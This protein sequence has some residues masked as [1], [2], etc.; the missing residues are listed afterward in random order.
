[1]SVFN[2]VKKQ[3]TPSAGAGGTNMYSD[4]GGQA[5]QGWGPWQRQFGN[6]KINPTDYENQVQSG[7]FLDLKNNPFFQ[8]YAQGAMGDMNEEFQRASGQAMSPFANMNNFMSGINAATQGRMVDQHSENVNQAMS[9]MYN[10]Q[11]G[12]ERDRQQQIA[13]ILSGRQQAQWGVM[14][15]NY[16]SDQARIASRGC[17][18]ARGGLSLR[19]RSEPDRLDV[20]L[21]SGSARQPGRIG[22]AAVRVAARPPCGHGS[23]RTRHQDV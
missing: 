23:P 12:A 10:Q 4:S 6:A 17:P 21:G 14:G 7:Y 22:R 19:L 3:S 15:Q 18:R 16:G 9:G 13:D 5:A 20:W 2:E 1:M 8:D 11:F